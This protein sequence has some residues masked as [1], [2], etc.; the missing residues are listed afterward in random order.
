MH[1]GEPPEKLPGE[2]KSGLYQ[3]LMFYEHIV[4]LCKIM[5]ATR[6]LGG[7]VQVISK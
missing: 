2:G 4:V 3:Y 1:D 5:S 7:T 6:A